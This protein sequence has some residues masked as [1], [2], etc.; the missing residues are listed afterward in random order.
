[1]SGRGRP[2]S[3]GDTPCRVAGC[4]IRVWCKGLCRFHDSRQRLGIPLDKPKHFKSL[5]K[6]GWIH[7]EYRWMMAPGGG[8][9]MEHRY[10]MEQHLGRK[11]HVDEIVHHK[12]GIKTDNRLENLEVQPRDHHTSLH[13]EHQT[14]CVV[15]GITDPHGTRGRC[16]VHHAQL[17]SPVSRRTLL[18]DILQW[19]SSH[20]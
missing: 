10:L 6:R 16:A 17:L 3:W 7:H 14:P 1:M 12:N 9:V 2:R 8:E 13:R 11:L 20:V 15:C 5:E 19:K 18:A 4:T